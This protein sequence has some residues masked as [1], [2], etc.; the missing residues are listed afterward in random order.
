[1]DRGAAA[2]KPE[3]QC[4]VRV[5]QHRFGQ[6]PKPRTRAVVQEDSYLKG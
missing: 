4:A 6:A 3:I 2:G 1:M 5:A